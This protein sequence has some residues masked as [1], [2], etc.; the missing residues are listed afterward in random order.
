MD[1][2]YIEIIMSLVKV[3]I[4]SDIDFVLKCFMNC[5]FW[6]VMCV[7]LN[8]VIVSLFFGFSNVLEMNVVFILF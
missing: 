2:L 4:V 3:Y 5:L 1:E 6:F 8:I 7:L